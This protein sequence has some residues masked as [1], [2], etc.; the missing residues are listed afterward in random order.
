MNR[1][2]MN[3]SIITRHAVDIGE[4]KDIENALAEQDKRDAILDYIAACDHP[5][6]FEEDEEEMTNE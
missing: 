6:I 5:E 4:R 1:S 3:R 2:A